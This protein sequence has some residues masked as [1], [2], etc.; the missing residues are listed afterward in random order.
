M[1]RIFGKNWS[2]SSISSKFIAISIHRKSNSPCSLLSVI[3]ISHKQQSLISSLHWIDHYQERRVWISRNTYT[4]TIV[5]FRRCDSSSDL[6]P[7]V[8]LFFLLFHYLRYYYHHYYSNCRR[9]YNQ[10]E[11]EEKKNDE[12]YKSWR[13]RKKRRRRR[14]RRGD[15]ERERQRERAEKENEVVQPNWPDII[16]TF[17]LITE[18]ICL[19]FLLALLWQT[20]WRTRKT[21]R[22]TEMKK[23]RHW[24]ST[25]KLK[26][27]ERR[28]RKKS[29]KYSSWHVRHDYWCI[30]QT[31]V[32]L[33]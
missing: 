24:K 6:F 32:S 8:F 25:N 29:G 30:N 4:D 19:R 3:E 1:K 7:S 31:M 22:T 11:A 18:L 15:R 10:R 33:P 28:C 2:I 13:S 23:K 21:W 14:R 9:W 27:R 5:F 26:K 16:S 17:I 12:G 20:W